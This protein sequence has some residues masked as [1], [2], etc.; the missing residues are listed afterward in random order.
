MGNVLLAQPGIHVKAKQLPWS[1][2]IPVLEKQ[3][4]RDPWG[5]SA[6]KNSQN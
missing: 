1:P 4:T 3:K 5:K 2:T 6:S